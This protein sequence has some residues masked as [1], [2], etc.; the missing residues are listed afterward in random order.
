[1]SST[2][3][4]QREAEED[5]DDDDDD[6][7]VEQQQ[8]NNKMKN[9]KYKNKNKMKKKKNM[10]RRRRRSNF[11]SGFVVVVLCVR[12]KAIARE[13]KVIARG[14]REGERERG[15]SVFCLGYGD[16]PRVPVVVLCNIKLGE[17]VFRLLICC[18][19]GGGGRENVAGSSRLKESKFAAKKERKSLG[20]V[21][22]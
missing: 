3:E 21:S 7:D 20:L 13:Q 16:A 5:E 14:G 9:K 6:D 8:Q 19:V 10:K 1:L 22:V 11:G 2:Q 12:E 17:T 15:G 18:S 4:Q